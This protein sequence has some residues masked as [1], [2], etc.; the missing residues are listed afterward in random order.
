MNIAKQL[1][2]KLGLAA[3][4]MLSGTA[5]AGAQEVK[6]MQN[7]N[8]LSGKDKT[9]LSN[10]NDKSLELT[11]RYG[12]NDLVG[13]TMTEDG[14]LKFW[15]DAMFSGG[16]ELKNAHGGAAEVDALILGMTD[17]TGKTT[18][19]TSTF[20]LKLKQEFKG[21]KF[22]VVMGQSN[23]GA[24][25]VFPKSGDLFAD[26]DN[27]SF[28][29]PNNKCTFMIEKEGVTL[30]V[31]AMGKVDDGRIGF[32]LPKNANPFVRVGFAK[33]FNDAGGK[34]DFNL[35]YQAGDAKLLIGTAR[36]QDAKKGAKAMTIYSKDVGFKVTGGLWTTINNN[37]LALDVSHI[38]KQSTTQV[39][40]AYGIGSDIQILGIANFGKDTKTF[41]IGASKNIN[42]FNGKHT[43]K[44][45]KSLAQKRKENRQIAQ[46]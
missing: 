13:V 28:L 35:S 31:G 24:G 40:I 27:F 23:A 26:R 44:K 42:I 46:Y 16:V 36:I 7:D 41:E 39:A 21:W 18:F 32:F 38:N 6:N 4:M 25:I 15:N 8:T 1:K 33:A 14:K 3:A 45:G 37:L 19:S 30:E 22:S 29:G 2:L 10:D 5:Y 43:V 11:G 20:L 34:V 9:E 17:E 12:L